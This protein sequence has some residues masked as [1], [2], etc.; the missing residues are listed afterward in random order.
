MSMKETVKM[1]PC[2]ILEITP[3]FFR[4]E[5]YNGIT[6][7]K[8]I[9]PNTFGNREDAESFCRELNEEAGLISFDYDV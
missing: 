2:N 4:V 1:C 9:L 6:G 5:R 3:S 8:E 7:Q